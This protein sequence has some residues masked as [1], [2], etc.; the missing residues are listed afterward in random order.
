MRL[1]VLALLI[2][3]VAG[4]A[5]SKR[6]RGED[7]YVTTYYDRNGDGIIDFELHVLPG[8]SDADWALSDTNFSGKYDIRI[9]FGH[10]VT[11]EPIYKPVPKKAPIT[12]GRPPVFTTE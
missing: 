12:A 2:A 10:A 4:C 3:L 11:R 7:R 5:S 1:A 8:A 9:R 6:D